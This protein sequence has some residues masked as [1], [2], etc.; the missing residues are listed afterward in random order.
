[1]AKLR[2]SRYATALPR[3]LADDLYLSTSTLF[4]LSTG[5]PKDG[6]DRDEVPFGVPDHL[7]L[8][9]WKDEKLVF[10]IPPPQ[11]G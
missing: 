5:H 8:K 10:S 2:G 4:T 7:L 3:T 6:A 9:R 11:W 1:M